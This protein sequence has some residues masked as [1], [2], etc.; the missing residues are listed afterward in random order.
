[1]DQAQKISDNTILVTKF[2]EPGWT[3]LF[4]RLAGVVT[5]V[6]GILSHAAIISREYNLP[7]VLNVKE[8]TTKLKTGD[9]VRID[10]LKGTVEILS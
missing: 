8:A 1:L 4:P 2:T 5:E 10:G 6:G 3:P 9:K 7:A